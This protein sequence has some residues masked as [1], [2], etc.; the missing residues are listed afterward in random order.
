MEN[1][2]RKNRMRKT[3]R[4]F[5][6]SFCAVLIFPVICFVSLYQMSFRNIYK[7]KLLDKVE[8]NL[9]SVSDELDRDLEALRAFVNYNI[10]REQFIRAVRGREL[11]ESEVREML[12]SG[13]ASYPFLKD[14]CYYNDESSNGIYTSTGTY[15]LDYY[16]KLYIGEGTVDDFIMQLENIRWSGWT[17]WNKG[18]Q[19]VIRDTEGDYWIFQISVT[20]LKKILG[21]EWAFTMLVDADGK[22]LYQTG[23]VC[24][25]DDYMITYDSNLETYKLIR[26]LDQ[27]IIFNELNS[28][29]RNF[30][31]VTIVI[32]LIGGVMVIALTFYNENP[33]IELLTWIRRKVQNIPDDMEGY[34][35]IK[36]ALKSVGEQYVLQEEKHRR[37]QLLLRLVYG[38]ECET[39]YFQE[40]MKK[41]GLFVRAECWRIVLVTSVENQEVDVSKITLYLE[42]IQKPE[43]EFRQIDIAD[44]KMVLYIVGMTQEAEKEI[45]NVLQKMAED[46]SESVGDSLW[47]YVGGRY[48]EPEKIY[49]SYAQAFEVC[50]R[51]CR[52]NKGR[53]VFYS[54]EKGENAKFVYPRAELAE[55]YEKLVAVDVSKVIALTNR[56]LVVMMEQENS[57]FVYNSLYYDVI[58]TYFRAI[59]SLEM[60]VGGEILEADQFVIRNQ[61]DAVKLIKKIMV[62]YRNTVEDRKTANGRMDGKELILR[63]IAFIDENIQSADLNVSMVADYFKI[64]ISN[65][66]HKFK[67]QTNQ[68]ISDYIMEKRFVYACRLLEET[69]CRVKDIA[70]KLGY[71]KPYSFIR[72]FKQRGGMT[73]MEYRSQKH[74]EHG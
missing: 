31:I 40:C 72:M 18:L 28:W 74:N 11:G 17:N 27:D 47:F 26:Y 56:L 62:Q 20:E 8:Y 73:P 33:L 44:Q 68:T 43:M 22:L 57:Q 70:D 54:F 64:T 1:I 42:V 23:K 67:E 4:R 35:I 29:Q 41:E 34:D 32:I 49:L 48:S 16:A 61:T 39:P 58:N 50:Q 59:N 14:I 55:L 25:E 38:I 71:I 21:E 36:Y 37:S 63:V 52:E 65:L 7:E 12:R 15:L 24:Q 10:M 3:F 19:Y 60:S 2:E 66:S 9:S 30:T 51:G 53:V 45:E 6:F 46:I 69:D 5:V 13:V